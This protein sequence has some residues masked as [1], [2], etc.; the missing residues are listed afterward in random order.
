[1]L[2]IISKLLVA[3]LVFVCV[4]SQTRLYEI[5]KELYI[6]KFIIIA[7]IGVFFLLIILAK[8]QALKIS[9]SIRQIFWA[10][11]LWFFFLLLSLFNSDDPAAGALLV[12]SYI[13]MFLL[14]G[15]LI[16]NCS[17]KGDYLSYNKIF[18]GSICFS[19][20]IV[21]ILSIKDPRSF[22][23]VGSRVRYQALFVNPN[24]LGMY[25][26][27]GLLCSYQVWAINHQRRY[28]VAAVPFLPLL[29]LSNS[30]APILA[31]VAA[32][33]VLA[34]LA[35]RARIT[36][37]ERPLLHIAVLLLIGIFAAYVTKLLINI[38]YETLDILSSRRLFFWSQAIESLTGIEWFLGQGLGKIGPGKWGYDSYYFRALVETG[39]CGLSALVI[40]LMSTF[41][42]LWRQSRWAPIVALVALTVYSLFETALVSIGNLLSIYVWMNIGYHLSSGKTINVRCALGMKPLGALRI[43][44][45]LP[46]GY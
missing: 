43:D 38:P 41:W 7:L 25:S 8:R 13:I 30:R 9:R 46:A 45:G 10:F 1:M 42:H 21:I 31:A 17:S 35:L 20:M 22:C 11:S 36:Y 24:Y 39:I 18:L 15:I 19:L 6:A 14:F 27:L 32:V 26:L 37:R 34:Y 40:L 4:F 29:Y 2:K 3:A 44:A 23:I 5:Q 28:V 16:P 33:L 12:L